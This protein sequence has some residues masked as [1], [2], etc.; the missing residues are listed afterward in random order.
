MP[1]QGQVTVE[2]EENRRPAQST[3]KPKTGHFIRKCQEVVVI[4]YS[5]VN[6]IDMR[7]GLKEQ[8]Y[9]EMRWQCHYLL[10]YR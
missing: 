3:R 6:V 10:D 4:K 2:I 1:K 7:I 9:P 5:W 8:N